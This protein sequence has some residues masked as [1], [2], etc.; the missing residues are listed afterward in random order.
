[1][2]HIPLLT[3]SLVIATLYAALFHLM[4]G[5]TLQE[6]LIYWVAAVAGFASGHLIASALSWPDVLIGELH[7]VAASLASWLFL[8]F[9][10]R[11][12]S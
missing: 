6:L 1:M 5:R 8:A 3:L 10:Q 9:A 12:K 4:R 7:L 11:L 2:L